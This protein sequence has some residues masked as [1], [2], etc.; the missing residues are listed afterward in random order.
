[1]DHQIDD[2]FFRKLLSITSLHI[3]G[4]LFCTCIDRRIVFLQLRHQFRIA[5]IHRLVILEALHQILQMRH[6][7]VVIEAVFLNRYVQILFNQFRH[8]IDDS[9]RVL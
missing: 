9:V 1:M 4:D 5:A 7:A 6:E 3:G 2:L 8:L